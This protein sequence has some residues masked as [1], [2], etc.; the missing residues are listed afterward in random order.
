MIT[1]VDSSWSTSSTATA[2]E[3]QIQLP[4]VVATVAVGALL[5]GTAGGL[6]DNNDAVELRALLV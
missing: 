6:S 4:E 3:D 5:T 2:A 1:A